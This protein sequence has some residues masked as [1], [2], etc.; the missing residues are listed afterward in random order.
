MEDRHCGNR[1]NPRSNP[2]FNGN[3]S[4][5]SVLVGALYSPRKGNLNLD[6]IQKKLRELTDIANYLLEQL[7]EVR[8]MS[9]L[10]KRI[11][12]DETDPTGY[13]L[14]HLQPDHVICS[15]GTEMIKTEYDK[16]LRWVCPK[17][18]SEIIVES[19]ERGSRA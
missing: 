9:K 13:A 12:V 15:C 6:K 3:S 18:G 7:R 10:L 4:H 8:Q 11:V 16:G 1:Q 5:S 17:C 2:R 14:V 19:P